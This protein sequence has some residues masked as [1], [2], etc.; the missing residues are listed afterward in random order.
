MQNTGARHG[1]AQFAVAADIGGTNIRAAVVS[2]DGKVHARQTAP[3]HPERGIE[4]AAARLAALIGKAMAATGGEAVAGVGV[5]TAGPV[6]PSSGTYNH[7]PNLQGWHNRT[8]RPTLGR[9][10][11]L[12]VWVG[13]DATL[14]ALAETRHGVNK[15]AQNLIYIT[16]ST[17]IGGGIIANGEM[18]TGATG[19]AGAKATINV[20]RPSTTSSV[21]AMVNGLWRSTNGSA[22]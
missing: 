20:P 21:R 13:H 2:R 11:G 15:G 10:T 14:A 5:S 4:D 12:N 19:H 16:L 1:P 18:V 17:G 7:P 6:E 3:T 22:T 8:M 9:L